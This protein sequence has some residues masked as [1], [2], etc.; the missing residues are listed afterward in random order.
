L[1]GGGQ[2][3]PAGELPSVLVTGAS[4]F[5]GGHLAGALLRR[6]HVVR[7]IYRRENPPEHLRELECLGAEL[8][9]LDLSSPEAAREAVAGM[10]AVVHA[11]GLADYWGSYE[12]F[13]EL[14]YDLT[15]RL[16]EEAR[17]AGCRVF[18]YVSSVVVQGF[19]EHPDSTEEGPCYP[20]WHPY[21]Q[22]KKMAE[23]YVL[24]RNGP[25][26][27]T[28]AL[29]PSNVYGPRDTTMSARILQ[30]LDSGALIRLGGPSRRI[31]L[32]YIDDVLQAAMLA[33]EREQSAGRVFNITSGESVTL[34]EA[35]S[36]AFELMGKKPLRITVPLF[37]ARFVAAVLELC[38]RLVHARRAPPLARYLVEQISHDYHFRIDLAREVLGYEPRVGCREGIA[39]TLASFGRLD[40]S[41]AVSKR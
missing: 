35:L 17:E 6:G 29:R 12:R 18:L 34:E 3:R 40:P 9:R 5:V 8:L 2:G 13:R 15:V 28:V 33:L 39:R 30:A 22:T 4:G 11:A 14:N 38:F 10:Q 41:H 26:F 21:A 37:L 1:K 32:V 20:L 31:S 23:Q 7:A 27:R 25:D 24:A 36:C 19:G 16:L